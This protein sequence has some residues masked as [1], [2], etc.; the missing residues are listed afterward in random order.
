LGIFVDLAR[1]A[2]MGRSRACAVTR[3]AMLVTGGAED[4]SFALSAS[5]TKAE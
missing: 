5:S 4:R 2:E 1:S 3:T